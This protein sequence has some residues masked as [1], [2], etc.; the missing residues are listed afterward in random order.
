MGVQSEWGEEE[1]KIVVVARGGRGAAR[2]RARGL[3]RERLPRFMVP[4]YV[5]LAAALPKTPTAKV[6]KRELRAAGVTAATWD[7]ERRTE[8]RAEGRGTA[9][10]A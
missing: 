7:R 1:V 3:P 4:R 2:G 9:A 10:P 6:R 5:E 8:P